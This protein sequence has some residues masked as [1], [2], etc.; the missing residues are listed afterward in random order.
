VYKQRSIYLCVPVT[1]IGVFKLYIFCRVSIYCVYVWVSVYDC[2]IPLVL[3]QSPTLLSE[4]LE[5]LC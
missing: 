2:G 1:N 5:S 3:F 4:S